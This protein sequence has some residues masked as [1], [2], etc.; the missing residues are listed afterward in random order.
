MIYLHKFVPNFNYMLTKEFEYYLANQKDLVKKYNGKVLVI[1]GQQVIGVYESETEAYFKTIKAHDLGT[2]L[3]Q[4]C[5]P[6]EESYTQMY[7]SRVT[8][9]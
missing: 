2:F 9:V 4:K 5:E 3:I 7:N 8:F 6:G 1:K